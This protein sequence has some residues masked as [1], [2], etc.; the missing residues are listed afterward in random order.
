MVGMLTVLQTYSDESH[1][2]LKLK[3][4]HCKL[5]FF[6]KILTPN[7]SNKSS[8][9]LLFTVLW[10]WKTLINNKMDRKVDSRSQH[11]L[12]QAG[13]KSVCFRSCYNGYTH[14]SINCIRWPCHWRPLVSFF[15]HLPSNNC[16]VTY[17]VTFS[18]PATNTLRWNF[19]G[20]GPV[21]QQGNTYKR[22]LIFE[23]HKHFH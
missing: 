10:N 22:L 19:F 18:R 12:F 23:F 21:Y 7:M 1:K 8:I 13:N 6:P 9:R 2:H 5:N 15:L 11:S 4:N 16:N 3:L 14:P 17:T 20:G